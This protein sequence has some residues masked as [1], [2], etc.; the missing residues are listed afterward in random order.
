MLIVTVRSGWQGRWRQP[1]PRAP[2]P[3]RACR[4][5][6][7][8]RHPRAASAPQRREAMPTHPA[9]AAG[10]APRP[11]ARHPWGGE[12]TGGKGREG[13]E[14]DGRERDG[15]GWDGKGGEGAGGARGRRGPAPEPGPARPGRPR[16]P[17]R[18]WGRGNRDI[19]CLHINPKLDSTI[20]LHAK[21]K[22]ERS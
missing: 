15:M 20:Q 21:L 16:A 5:R 4:A 10:P 6:A 8:C 22:G 17:C 1:T 19:P 14:G 2:A 3:A 7:A 11:P 12:G 9:P 18:G 13:R